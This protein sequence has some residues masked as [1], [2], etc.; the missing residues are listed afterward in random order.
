MPVV[1]RPLLLVF[2][3]MTASGK[4]TLAMAWAEAQGIPYYNTDRIRK[5]LAGVAATT[6]CPDGIN[7]G[8]YTADLS[9]RTY[10]T[11]LDKAA[12]DIAAGKPVVVLDGSYGK[13]SDRDAVR[14]AA[15]V[16]GIQCLFCYCVCSQ[17]ETR[18]RFA[19]RAA[20]AA[21]VSDGRWEIYQYQQQHFELPAA[22]EKDAFVVCTEAPVAELV[23]TITAQFCKKN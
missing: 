18:R 21:A 4:S 8:I 5:D 7:Q 3:G 17:E 1:N 6:K 14:Q 10:Q 23:K 15:R 16:L 2:F 13:R 11:M 20:D 12:G 9:T 22:D 19:L